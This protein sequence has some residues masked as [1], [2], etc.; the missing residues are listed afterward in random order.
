MAAIVIFAD[1]ITKVGLEGRGAVV[2]NGSH[3]GLIAASMAIDAGVRAAI[4]NDAG[5][6]LDEAGVA[7]LGLLQSLGIP[8]AAISHH[9]A[10]IG[11]GRDMMDRGV[12]SRCNGLAEDLGV[13]PGQA[14]AAAAD[15]L[16]EAA[17]VFIDAPA[18]VEHRTLAQAGPPAVWLLDSASM[19][20]AED[21][22]CIVVTGSHGALLG[23]RPDTAVKAP[24]LAALFNDAGLGADRAGVSRLCALQVRGIA[25][26]AV[27]A[28][29]ARI[30]DARSTYEDGI[31]SACN[32]LAKSLR[33]RVG[34]SAR[35]AVRALAAH[36]PLRRTA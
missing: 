31:I 33:V 8:A 20:T 29:S 34:A 28:D 18:H 17:I 7:G 10:R 14:C 9:S 35:D 30:G 4:F 3:G 27:S 6:G 16:A 15:C 22:G 2:V 1:S 32:P 12:I 19:V 26:A 24:V 21:A 23:G 13:R 25:A 5:I 36:A 11:D